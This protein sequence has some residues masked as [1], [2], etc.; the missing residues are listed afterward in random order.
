MRSGRLR[1]VCSAATMHEL[2]VVLARP[3]I[4]RHVA[5]AQAE[6]LTR[7]LIE[8]SER[9]DPGPAPG[10][11]RDPNDDFLLA[12]AAVSKA[13]Y[14]VTRDTDL[15]VLGRHGVTEII[16]PARFLQLLQALSS[17]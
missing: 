11:C 7:L 8:A 15:L 9:F 10:I 14:L 6:H 16:Y 17:T 4:A 1:L 5:A 12:L 2:A 3:R 13:D